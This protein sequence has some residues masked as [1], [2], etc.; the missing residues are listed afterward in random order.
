MLI[1]DLRDG[2]RMLR[3][4]PGFT[5]VATLTLPLGIGSTT[6]IS[7]APCERLWSR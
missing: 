4:S 2:L 7:R 1:S 5:I 6:A 3:R